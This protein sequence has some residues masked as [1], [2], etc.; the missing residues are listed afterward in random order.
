MPRPK[1]VTNKATMPKDQALPIPP[2]YRVRIQPI[3]DILK[4]EV[5]RAYWYM[6]AIEKKIMLDPTSVSPDG[7]M[8]AVTNYTDRMRE[9]EKTQQGMDKKAPTKDYP[10]YDSAPRYSK[11]RSFGVGAGVRTDN[12]IT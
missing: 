1:G 8:K 10:K 9:Y 12:P 6:L 4:Y 7:Y 11:G 2:V 5:R 3:K